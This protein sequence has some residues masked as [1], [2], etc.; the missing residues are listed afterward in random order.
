MG[1]AHPP[2]FA[3][4]FTYSRFFCSALLCSALSL[5]LVYKVP[6]QRKAACL[7]QRAGPEPTDLEQRK[8]PTTPSKAS[9]ESAWLRL[10]PPRPR[11]IAA[12]PQGAPKREKGPYNGKVD[13]LGHAPCLHLRQI[14]TSLRSSRVTG[15][16]I[17]NTRPHG[18]Q[19]HTGR[20]KCQTR[21]RAVLLRKA[22]KSE[23]RH[24]RP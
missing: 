21:A 3:V 13:G 22:A 9:S 2:R 17:V 14:D 5:A 16:Y 18:S 24:F 12:K 1:R 23:T 10:S 7:E 19:P 15:D 11:F 8:Y 20:A 6:S 4:A